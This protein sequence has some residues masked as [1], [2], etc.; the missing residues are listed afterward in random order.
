MARSLLLL[1]LALLLAG[2]CCDPRRDGVWSEGVPVPSANDMERVRVAETRLAEVDWVDLPFL[3]AVAYLRTVTGLNFFVTPAARKAAAD[4]ARVSFKGVDIPLE[5][6]L[7]ALTQSH[8]L[9]WSVKDEIVFIQAM[10]ERDHDLVVQIHAIADLV[11]GEG[12]AWDSAEAAVADVTANV[13]PGYW[14]DEQ[15]I[16][17]AQ[18]QGTLVIKASPTAQEAV[19]AYVDGKRSE[20]YWQAKRVEPGGR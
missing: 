9:R 17:R 7:T 13:M 20:R 8:D 12:R 16:V 14:K 18:G 4:S 3:E 6:L 5:D 19:A 1:S 11:K 10:A 2:C 15:H